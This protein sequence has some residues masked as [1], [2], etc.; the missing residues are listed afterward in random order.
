MSRYRCESVPSGRLYASIWL[1]IASC[2]ELRHQRPVAADRALD[3]ARAARADSARAPCRRRARRRTPASDRAAT[4]VSTKR[5]S[6]AA[7]SSSGVPMPTKPENATVS[8]SRI[9]AIASSAL[10]ILSLHRDSWSRDALRRA[11]AAMRYRPEKVL[12][13]SDLLGVHQRRRVPAARDLDRLHPAS[14]GRE[15]R[16]CISR[17]VSATAG[18]SARRAGSAPGTRP[19]PTAAT[20]RRRGTSGA[21]LL[22]DG[23]VVVEAQPA[24]VLHQR[25][26][27]PGGATGRRVSWPNGA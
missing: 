11:C 9:S 20:A 2:R 12:D 18:R 13:R 8:P 16:R 22:H 7:I 26:A 10:T 24:V 23:R 5:R 3:Q 1:S 4:C 25:C 19:A 14:R 15:P 17:T 21:E 27:R 6:S